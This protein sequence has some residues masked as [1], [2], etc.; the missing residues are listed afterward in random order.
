MT[1][2]RNIKRKQKNILIKALAFVIGMFIVGAFF[3]QFISNKKTCVIEEEAEKA[4]YDHITKTK[5]F[6][7]LE[8]KLKKRNVQVDYIVNRNINTGFVEVGLREVREEHTTHIATFCYD[9]QT[10]KCFVYNL[11]DS[12]REIS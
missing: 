8:E 3:V 10:K 1:Q 4:S 12:L 9:P 6:L 5:E 7:A 11:D 2:K